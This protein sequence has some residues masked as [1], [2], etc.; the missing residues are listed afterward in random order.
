MRTSRE[1]SPK[2]VSK[3]KVLFLIHTLGGG[4]AEKVLVDTVNKLDRNKFD[5]TVM[6]VINTGV[7]RDKI[8]KDINYRTIVSPPKFLFS[9]SASGSMSAGNGLKVRVFGFI[10]NTI[11]KFMP[12]RLVHKLYIGDSYD[13]EIAF[14]EGISAKIIAASGNKNSK[15]YGWIHIDFSNEHK[16]R[17]VFV[18]KRAEHKTYHKFDRLFCVSKNT[19]DGF[20][21]TVGDVD[22][23]DVLHNIVDFDD[24]FNKA[25]EK[26]DDK[27]GA[28]SEGISLVTV[29]RLSYQKGYD[30][31]LRVVKRLNSEKALFHLDIIGDGPDKDALKAYIEDNNLSNVKLLGFQKNPYK[32]IANAD[33]FVISSRAEGF[34]TVMTESIAVGTPVLST[35]VSGSE[36]LPE[37]LV[38]ENGEQ[39]IYNG[40]LEIL[41]DTKVLDRVTAK[42]TNL[43][44]NLQKESDE[45]LKK[46]ESL[47]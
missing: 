37:E 30:R 19:R 21:R 36:I 4:G 13:T 39:G 41:Q 11:W 6:T 28:G 8:C 15:K 12:L 27:G 23:V 24:V 9:S 44:K 10:Y 42:I 38:V 18:S 7:N 17:H 29:G 45:S 46:L 33:M 35:R 3:R 31:L 20:L 40:L 22:N 32:Y 43:R 14:L 2:L 16:S 1:K 26:I 5:I 25:K 34:S 47:L